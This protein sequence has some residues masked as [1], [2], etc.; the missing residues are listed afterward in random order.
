VDIVNDLSFALRCP[1]GHSQRCVWHV[2]RYELLFESGALALVDSYP[3][4][5]VTSFAVSLERFYEF[6]L[7]AVL[8]QRGVDETAWLA[9]WKQVKQQERQLGAFVL[10][11]RLE[12][13][14][15]APLLPEDPWVK[16]RNNVVHAG[17][18]PSAAEA[19][20]Y[21]ERVVA[22]VCPLAREIRR[23]APK[24]VVE[25]LR[26]Q[27]SA[28]KADVTMQQQTIL[29]R[30]TAIKKATFKLGRDLQQLRRRQAGLVRGGH[31]P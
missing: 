27:R 5:A 2:P 13:G 10:M 18:W 6:W 22:Y 4:E 14:K 21:G 8:A 16:F 24:G 26:R 23:H 12:L 11:Y 7:Q 19:Q 17:Y 15:V 20:E 25:V 9:S 29:G 3:R 31:H 28:A 1:E 30:A